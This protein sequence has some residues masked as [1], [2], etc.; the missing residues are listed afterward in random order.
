MKKYIL[1]PLLVLAYLLTACIPEDTPVSPYEPGDVQSR[2]I[3][4]TKN[5][6]NQIF[7]DLG[8]NSVVKE[9]L[10]DVWDLG[11]QCSDEG[12]YV[13]LNY[14]KFMKAYNTG[15]TDF[16]AVTTHDRNKL[17]FDAPSGNLDSTIIGQWWETSEESII[18][19]NEVYIIERGINTRN[20]RMG[21]KKMQI[22]GFDDNKYHI[23]YA[24]LNGNNLHEFYIE[25]D[26]RFNFIM[27][28]FDG[29]GSV[30]EFEPEKERWDLLFTKH[31]AY[32]P[33]QGDF[34]EYSVV[35]AL[36]NQYGTSAT[37]INLDTNNLNINHFDQITFE[38]AEGLPLQNNRNVIGHQWKDYLFEG[39]YVVFPYKVYIIKDIDGFYYK[40][41]FIEF[42]NQDPESPEYGNT[43]FPMFE[44]RR[45]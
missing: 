28:D 42:Y 8:T 20:R 1:F 35:G 23:K 27:F 37:M 21:L 3:S 26:N 38:L 17:M 25:K 7:F 31:N 41:N 13:I 45:L 36:I 5:Y 18:S 22:L 30:I 6:I 32:L 10:F 14:A 33:F 12:Y 43:G 29:G 4:M 16:D 11:F 34:I 9:D 24:D 2:T 19:K 40:L 39:G 44:F 15:L